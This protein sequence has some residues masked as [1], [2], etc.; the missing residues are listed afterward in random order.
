MRFHAGVVS[1]TLSRSFR[2]TEGRPFP[3]AAM[4]GVAMCSVLASQSV[5][6]QAYPNFVAR[7][8]VGD[9]IFVASNSVSMSSGLFGFKGWWPICF[10]RFTEGLCF[11][12]DSHWVS[13]EGS[14][15]KEMGGPVQEQVISIA[16]VRECWQSCPDHVQP[17][18]LT[19][20][21][22]LSDIAAAYFPP[23]HQKTMSICE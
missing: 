12:W 8:P 16:L 2:A 21:Y 15:G 1:Y 7:F 23:L 22:Q 18:S 14:L 13:M 5:G 4:S 10:A 6:C 11:L 3:P 9:I 19:W 17:H 20:V